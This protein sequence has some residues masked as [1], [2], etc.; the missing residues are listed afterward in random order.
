MKRTAFLVLGLVLLA[1]LA[2]ACS[3]ANIGTNNSPPEATIELP[4]VTGDET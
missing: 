1:L 3:D 4:L 2:S